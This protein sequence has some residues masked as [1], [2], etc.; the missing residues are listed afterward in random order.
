LRP[1]PAA[2]ADDVAAYLK[3]TESL[4]G[5]TLVPPVKI[6]TCTFAWMQD[7]EGNTVGLSPEAP[8]LVVLRADGDKDP[9]SFLAGLP[10]EEGHRRLAEAADRERFSLFSLSANVGNRH[11]IANHRK[12]QRFFP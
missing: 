3:K 9:C 4:G 10:P 11:F 1:K 5:K 6:P 7:P 12:P 8:I 2:S